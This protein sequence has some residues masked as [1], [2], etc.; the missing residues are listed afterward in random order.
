MVTFVPMWQQS[1]EMLT[2]ED[3]LSISGAQTP[4]QVLKADSKCIKKG[5]KV[6]GVQWLAS[7]SESLIEHFSNLRFTSLV[8]TVAKLAKLI[9][10]GRPIIRN[11]LRFD[12]N[13]SKTICKESGWSS[14]SEILS[15]SIFYKKI[16]KNIIKK[17]LNK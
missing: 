14:L 15:V 12:P 9:R 17:S 8:Q 1:S 6:P 10:E 5:K 2:S 16:N 7:A 3:F 11:S 13:V 4:K